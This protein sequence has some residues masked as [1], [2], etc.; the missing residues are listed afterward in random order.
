MRDLEPLKLPPSHEGSTDGVGEPLVSVVT[1][2]PG[3]PLEAAC[4]VP[5]VLVVAQSTPVEW[6]VIDSWLRATKANGEAPDALELVP[7]SQPELL[8]RLAAGDDPVV[9]PVRVAWRPRERAGE[10]RTR[11]PDLLK[12][13]N[14][15]RPRLST[16]ARILRREPDRCAVVIGDPSTVSE[17]R[18]R[19]LSSVYDPGGEAEFAAYASRQGR[20]ALDRAERTWVGHRY[21]APDYVAEELVDSPQLRRDVSALA[22]RLDE[23]EAQV[24][25]RVA[26]Y[27]DEIVAAQSRFWIDVW[28]I[29]SRPWYANAWT[30]RAEDDR[31]D[32]LADLNRQHAL[33]FL[34]THRSYADSFLLDAILHEHG[35]PRNHVI[36]GK[37]MDFW[38]I[39]P[40]MRRTGVVFIR[41]SF[42]GDEAYKLAVRSFIGYLVE[43]RFNLEWYIENGR[44]RTGKL[45]PPSY[46]LLRYLIDA[47]DAG[48]ARDAYLVPVSITYD[49]LSEVS[50]MAAEE[51]GQ[52][53]Q[54]ESI[55]WYARF[56]RGQRQHIGTA[57][58]RFG[59][60]VSLRSGLAGAGADV[61]LRRAMQKVAFEVCD[62]I[63]RATP[64]MVTEPVTLALLGVRD[65]ALTLAEVRQVLEPLLDYV[66]R[67]GLPQIGLQ[68]LR[69]AGGL[70]KTLERLAR[71]GV[72]SCYAGGTEPVYSIEPGQYQVAAF[73]RN[74]AIH[75][76]LSRAIVETVLLDAVGEAKDAAREEVWAA[77]LRLRDLLKYEF[78]FPE[79]SAFR[80][81]LVAE[82]ELLDPEWEHRG[83]SPAEARALL[84]ESGFL[85]AHRVLRPFLESYLVVADRLTAHDPRRP[86]DK[87]TFLDECG[88]VGRQYVLQGR[89]H[90]HDSISR[91][92]FSHALELAANR[93]LI[94][95]GRADLSV[96][97][98]AFADEV[99]VMRALAAATEA[100]DPTAR[101]GGAGDV[102]AP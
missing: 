51:L 67:R 29:L 15:H 11:L 5:L 102:R 43:R 82:L 22:A 14:P 12:L 23:P 96:R 66:E 40:I 53:R 48:R 44:S 18:A 49:Q 52:P 28:T 25:Q 21:K 3:S 76:L 46:G 36:G 2:G 13:T 77:A 41:R 64:I 1:C 99:A 88:A 42:R 50:A 39:G 20:L 69:R 73:Y 98:R 27:L 61:D 79:R 57:T 75:W 89:L 72:V 85:V 54:S 16:Q 70:R 58:V 9:V 80:D 8:R 62:R 90:S 56:L 10:R 81:G 33:V 95:P 31:L 86:I 55:I 93:D 47:T 34:P 71:A 4:G 92:V 84:T 91:E 6:S 74:S 68:A 17:L 24:H 19:W 65:R 35:F 59:E 63:N 37:N 38:P 101:P 7:D 87:E 26:A 97:R 83:A 45:R 60:P 78:F 32:A 100:L 94:D 30:V